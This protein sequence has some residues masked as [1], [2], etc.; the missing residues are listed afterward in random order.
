MLNY[1]YIN[2]LIYIISS[3]LDSSDLNCFHAYQMSSKETKKR[4]TKGQEGI[5]K[6]KKKVQAQDGEEDVDA[7]DTAPLSIKKKKSK[8]VEVRYFLFT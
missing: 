8:N 3:N 7:E 6:K 5:T 4:K 2:G 1:P